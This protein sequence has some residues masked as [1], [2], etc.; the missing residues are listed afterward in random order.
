MGLI[1]VAK[2]AG[3]NP[4]DG[5]PMWYDVDGNIIF[6]NVN[7]A[8]DVEYK[9]GHAEFVGGYGTT[10]SYKG[11]SVDAFFQFSFGQW[12]HAGT[13]FYFTRTPDFLMNLNTEV[14]DRWKSPGDITYYPRA[15][16]GG[17]I[18]AETDN[19]RT[20]ESTQ[21][22]Y[23]TSY[24][25][26]KNLNVTYDIPSRFTDAIGIRG[27]SIYAA[28]V[29]LFT[30]TAWPWYDPEVARSTTDIFG[31]QIYASYPTEKTFY[32]GIRLQF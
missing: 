24:I 18:F 30:W 12:A 5:R 8:N 10:V 3:V 17:A 22:I 23:N 7:G 32:G 13:D 25:R 31:N 16:T 14:L 15:M 19:Y 9:D 21:G 1:Q 26:L 6:Q 27:A 28:G 4:A 29:N 2:W 20:T 11:L